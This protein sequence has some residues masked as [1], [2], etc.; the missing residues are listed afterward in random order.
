MRHMLRS[1]GTTLAHFPIELGW[2]PLA[3]VR[4]LQIPLYN[5]WVLGAEGKLRVWQSV[6]LNCVNHRY[7]CIAI[8]V[9]I[10]IQRHRINS[11][12]H[13]ILSGIGYARRLTV[14][15]I[16]QITGNR[17]VARYGGGVGKIHKQGGT[18]LKGVR[19]KIN[20]RAGIY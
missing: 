13:I 10:C 18:T 17:I 5:G 1:V 15:K 8:L 14:S 19:S 12:S 9:G 7:R 4:E 3:Q 6:H 11:R 20:P 2:I 16:P